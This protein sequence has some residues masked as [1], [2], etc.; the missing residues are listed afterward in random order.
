MADGAGVVIVGGGDLLVRVG[1]AGESH[2]QGA[3]SLLS[4]PL[5]LIIEVT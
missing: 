5:K 3:R 4:V 2:G 1:P